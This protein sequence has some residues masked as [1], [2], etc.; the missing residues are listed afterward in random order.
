MTVIVR[1]SLG[2]RLPNYDH[3]GVVYLLPE[4]VDSYVIITVFIHHFCSISRVGI[5]VLSVRGE[6]E[7]SLFY[8]NFV[9]SVTVFNFI[10]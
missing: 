8:D 6:F 9:N 7:L 10:Q 5:T 1:W 3:C 4:K 2:L